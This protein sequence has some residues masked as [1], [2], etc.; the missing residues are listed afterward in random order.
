MAALVTALD[1]TGATIW[2]DTD[3]TRDIPEGGMINV[4]EAEYT[5]EVVLSPL[6]YLHEMPAEIT[7]TIVAPDEAAR[8]AALDVLLLAISEALTADR[9]LGGAVEWLDI[10][11]PGVLPFEANGAAKAARFV[12]TLCFTTAGSPLA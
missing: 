5:P 6:S 9:T 8:D 1:A 7:V 3:L 12:I 4:A 2:R 10:S 11:V